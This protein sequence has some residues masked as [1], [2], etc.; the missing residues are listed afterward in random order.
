MSSEESFTRS[1]SEG[2]DESSRKGNV[3]KQSVKGRGGQPGGGSYPVNI[4]PKCFNT[5]LARA[6]HASSKSDRDKGKALSNRFLSNLFM[7]TVDAELV[8]EFLDSF[9]LQKCEDEFDHKQKD[10][11]EPEND[12]HSE[13]D[14]DEEKSSVVEL[15]KL[16]SRGKDITKGVKKTSEIPLNYLN[17]HTRLSDPLSVMGDTGAASHSSNYSVYPRG[18]RD[19]SITNSLTDTKESTYGGSLDEMSAITGDY[20]DIST[21]NIVD[22]QS[23]VS[24]PSIHAGVEMKLSSSKAERYFGKKARGDFF[25]KYRCM[26]NTKKFFLAPRT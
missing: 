26:G 4:K 2:I 7:P 22:D 6:N 13:K 14:I 16:D 25:E 18:S 20:T 5:M 24:L 8:G 12:G 10:G 9:D 19:I 3:P 23:Y 17:R 11:I 1:R 15:L 21:G